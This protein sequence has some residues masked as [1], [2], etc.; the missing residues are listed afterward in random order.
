MKICQYD[1]LIFAIFGIKRNN[2]AESFKA[3]NNTGKKEKKKK[4][5]YEWDFFDR[6]VGSVKC[7]FLCV[8]G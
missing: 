5:M 4:K 2:P 6:L 3:Q 1:L 8:K 7:L